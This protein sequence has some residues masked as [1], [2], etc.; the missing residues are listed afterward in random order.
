M[1]APLDLVRAGRA[2]SFRRA[3]I[4]SDLHNCA[5]S[6]LFEHGVTNNGPPGGIIVR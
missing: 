2:R 1:A 4:P 3:E 5:G 6:W